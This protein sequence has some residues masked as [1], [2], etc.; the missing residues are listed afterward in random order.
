[1]GVKANQPD[2]PWD[3]ARPFEDERLVAETGTRCRTVGLG[4]GR[5]E[6]RGCR[7]SAALAGYTDWPGLAQAACVARTRVRKATG[8]VRRERAS[9]VTSLPPGRADAA[10]L[11]ALNRGRWGIENRSHWVRD[12]TFGEDR[13]R[14]RAGGAPQV[15]AAL[16]NLAIAVLR[17]HGHAAIRASRDYFAGHRDAALALVGLGQ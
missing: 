6:V 10:A 17:L 2:L 12:A 11:L 7:A 1:M 8:E 14:I 4:H 13:A 9:L 16:R 15:A 3:L 5:V